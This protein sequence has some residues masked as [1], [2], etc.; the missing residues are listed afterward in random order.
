VQ[1]PYSEGRANHTDPESCAVRREAQGEALTGERVGWAIEPRKSINQGADAVASA[2]GNTGRHAK[3]VP[4]RPCVVEDPS[5]R[6]RS[7]C[8]NRE[9]SQ[10]ATRHECRL[11]RIGKA[12]GLKPMMH[13]GEKSDRCVVP[14]K[15]SNK[16]GRLAAER[17][18]GRRLVEGKPSE[19]TRPGRRADTSCQALSRGCVAGLHG[20]PKPRTARHY[21]L[22]QEPGAGIPL[23][24]ICAGGAQ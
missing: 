13:G 3:R 21:H 4:T 9:I 10:P 15:S 6:G 17:V 8:E 12:G 1:V 7:L 5:M 20:S 19:S 23:A 2:E 16:A 11:V 18:E 14:A 22:R 24:G